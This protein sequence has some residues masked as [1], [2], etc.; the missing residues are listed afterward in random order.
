V[1][2]RQTFFHF[3]HIKAIVFF[4]RSSSTT[5]GT[6]SNTQAW[7]LH[8][9][10]RL[11][12]HWT[13]QYGPIH[14]PSINIT[15]VQSAMRPLLPRHMSRLRTSLSQYW[16]NCDIVISGFEGL[17]TNVDGIKAIF[18]ISSTALPVQNTAQEISGCQDR[19]YS[20]FLKKLFSHLGYPH[21]ITYH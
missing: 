10:G 3:A 5:K 7:I 15:P 20:T 14:G 18:H 19:A 12:E 11:R 8:F 9:I 13:G 4:A 21:F 17:L 6:I 2:A 1:V 16:S